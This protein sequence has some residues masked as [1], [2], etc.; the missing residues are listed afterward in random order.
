MA[1]QLS[2]LDFISSRASPHYQEFI[3]REIAKLPAPLITFFQK[4]GY[5]LGKRPPMSY[6]RI[7]GKTAEEVPQNIDTDWILR[8]RQQE[9]P[10][11]NDDA[12]CRKAAVDYSKEAL[13]VIRGSGPYHNV[14]RRYML[15]GKT[16]PIRINA[17][18]QKTG[19]KV[20]VYAKCPD[21][22]RIVGMFLYN[23]VSGF[24]PLKYRFNQA[25]FIEDEVKGICL[26][27]HNEE[28][29]L[30]DSRY[31]EGI[32]R[33]AVHSHF[34]GMAGDVVGAQNRVV[35]AQHRTRLFDFD[36]LF[37]ERKGDLNTNYL[38]KHY[39][40]KPGFSENR[41]TDIMVEEMWLVGTRLENAHDRVLRLARV[42]GVLKDC[43]GR[44]IDERIRDYYGA[45]CL[46]DYIERLMSDYRQM[47][48]LLKVE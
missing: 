33:A 32:V 18:N 36:D 30:N 8:M 3:K 17:E 14:Q 28:I 13:K 47:G 26:L 44:T 1:Q 23:I 41:I 10:F 19:E 20:V 48:A 15:T 38:L 16:K 35:D 40:G 34:L 6:G 12:A 21:E 29:L 27:R 7:K 4:Q 24:E 31:R 25:V 2:T 46:E 22:N 37:P 5:Y 9:Y 11:N 45:L 42:A 39:L 43:T